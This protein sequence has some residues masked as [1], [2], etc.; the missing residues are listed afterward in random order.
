MAD[1][2]ITLTQSYL[3]SIFRYEDGKLYWNVKKF[4]V[5]NGSLAG[6]FYKDAYVKIRLDKKLYLAHRLIF[7]MFHGYLPREIDHINTNK[8]DNR[9]ENLRPA[10]KIQNQQ[11]IRISKS[12]TSGVKGVTW[13]KHHQ[14]YFVRCSV[15][16]TRIHLGYYKE[17]DDAKKVIED[18][19]LKHHGEFARLA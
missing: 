10:T 3:Q 13:N 4:K 2:H 7:M 8:H 16:G 1:K 14:K 18:F 19:R 5:K 12:N 6:C 9:I 17:L 15:D 11:N